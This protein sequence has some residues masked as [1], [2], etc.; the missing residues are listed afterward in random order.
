MV[1]SLTVH[2]EMAHG[3]SS[4]TSKSEKGFFDIPH[5]IVPPLKFATKAK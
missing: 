3:P 2:A 5:I 4:W 1:F